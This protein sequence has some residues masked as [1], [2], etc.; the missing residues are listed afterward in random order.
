MNILPDWA[1]GVHPLLIHFPIALLTIAIGLSVL[2]VFY[3]RRWLMKTIAVLYVT[4]VLG[5]LASYFSGKNAADNI[6]LNLNAEAA[7]G[8]HADWAFYTLLYFTG[9][10]VI[11]GVLMYVLK[12]NKII[13]RIAIALLALIGFYIL[14]Q[15]AEYGGRLVYLYGLGIKK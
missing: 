13:P 4:G 2:A 12:L 3:Y 8:A 11:Y 5:A 14:A 9:L 10:T 7:I 6:G 15:T 1:P